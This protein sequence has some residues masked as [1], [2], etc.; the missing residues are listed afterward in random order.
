MDTSDTNT[1]TT[2][3]DTGHPSGPA[4]LIPGTS[5]LSSVDTTS[6]DRYGTDVAGEIVPRDRS[7]VVTDTP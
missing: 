7:D 6:D 4:T 5:S 1:D 3:R 2:V